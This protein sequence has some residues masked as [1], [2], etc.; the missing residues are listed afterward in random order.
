MPDAPVTIT[1]SA[2]ASPCVEA[3]ITTTALGSYTCTLKA[4][5]VAPFFVVVTDPAGIAAPLVSIATNTPAAGAALTV[6]ATPLTTAIVAQLA[7]DGNPLSVVDSKTVDAAALKAVTDNVV[8]QLGPVLTSIGAPAGYDP[9]STSITAATAGNT[10]NTADAVLDVVKVVTDPASGKLAL[11]TIDNPTPVALATATSPGSALPTP[12][13]AV[14]TLSQATQLAAQKFEACFALPTAQRVL[15]T[16]NLPAA[17]GGPQVDAVG[18]ACEDF[19]SDAANAGTVDYLHNGYNAGQHFYGILTSDTMTG[20]KFSVPE[21]MALYPKN[22]AATAPAPD[23]YDR[24]VL[25]VRYL[26][27]NGNPGN[28]ITVAARVPG[29]SSA[30]RPTEW[31]LVGNQQSVDVTVRVNIRR[32]EQMN[33]SNTAKFSAFQNGIQFD[34]NAKGPG[35]VLGGVDSLT[36]ARVTGPGLPANGLVYKVSSQA[37]QPTMDLFNK[38]G[39]LTAGNQCG[40]GTTFNCPN[41]WFARTQ[42]LTGSAATTLAG[43]PAGMVWA[44]AADAID[45][46]KF[47]KGARYKVELFY[48]TNTGTADLVVFKTLLSDLIPVTNAVNLPW[49]TLGTNSLAAF[50]PAGSLAGAQTALP[51]DWV[52]NVSAQQVGGVRAAVDSTGSFGPSKPVPKGATSIVYDSATVPAFTTSSLRTILMGY[53][54]TDSSNKTAVYSYN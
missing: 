21:I 8:A 41:M 18:A 9:F 17:D 28:V 26:D 3:T 13:P 44:Q 11:A 16:T 19:V 50:D 45:T 42:G 39:S 5:E 29:S 31:W 1:N 49:N 32:F 6:N 47:V 25:N 43:N 27:A 14:T 23:A 51:I 4:G 15:A 12:D 48:G 33:A 53:R 54:V 24:A 10:G 35:S 36:L 37:S 52:Q 30:T 46:T 7:A 40:N 2:G 20:A 34:I 22:A 38:S